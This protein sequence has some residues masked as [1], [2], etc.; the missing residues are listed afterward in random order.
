MSTVDGLHD[1]VMPLSEV[2]TN[3]GTVPP[4]QMVSDVPK[5]NEGTRLGAT[6]TVKLAGTAQVPLAGVNVYVAEF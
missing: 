4:A 3:D 1:P 5:L 6:V 2:V